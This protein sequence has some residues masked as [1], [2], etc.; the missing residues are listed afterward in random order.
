M[1][2]NM[3]LSPKKPEGICSEWNDFLM[4]FAMKNKGKRNE[5]KYFCLY[6]KT[7]V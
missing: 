3:G 2:S 4:S 5:N 1:E 7:A 6:E